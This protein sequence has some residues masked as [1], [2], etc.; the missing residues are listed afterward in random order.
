MGGHIFELVRI[1]QAETDAFL[2]A[3]GYPQ[4][5]DPLGIIFGNVIYRRD[6]IYFVWNWFHQTRGDQYSQV[7]GTT[8]PIMLIDNLPNGDAVG[9]PDLLKTSLNI[10]VSA[11]TYTYN[12]QFGSGIYEDSGHHY[13]EI[14]LTHHLLHYNP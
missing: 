13:V 10:Q 6:L 14:A 2:V 4:M 7:P 9:Q 1:W 3:N 5:N 8:L 12:P 11:L